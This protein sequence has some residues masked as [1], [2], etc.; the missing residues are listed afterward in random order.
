MRDARLDRPL[1]R[2][3]G[4]VCAFGGIFFLVWG[5]SWVRASVL[6]EDL[7]SHC[8]DLHTAA[9]PFEKSCRHQDGTVEG[10]NGPLLDGVFYGSMAA[11]VVCLAAVLAIE[12]GRRR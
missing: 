10:A 2:L 3:W 12:A 1:N 8:D 6:N 4:A 9:F 11:A 7:H 5:L